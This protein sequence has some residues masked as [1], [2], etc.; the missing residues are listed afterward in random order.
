MTVVV[1]LSAAGDPGVAAADVA[2]LAANGEAVVVVCDGAAAAEDVLAAFRAVGVPGVALDEAAVLAGDRE[3][4]SAAVLAEECDAGCV[5]VVS[6]DVDR[7]AAAIAGALDASLVVVADADGVSEAVVAAEAAVAG[8]VAEAVV[9]DGGRRDPVV[10]GLNGRA[11]IRVT[12]S[13][14]G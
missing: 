10:R 5:P 13:V 1:A 11:G 8:G 12:P 2:H 14:G 7:A 9:V 4:V 3:C 6:G